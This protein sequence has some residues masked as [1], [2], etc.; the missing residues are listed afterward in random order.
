MQAC[1]QRR[2]RR[3]DAMLSPALMDITAATMVGIPAA[4]PTMANIIIAATSQIPDTADPFPMVIAP[5]SGECSDEPSVARTDLRGRCD[6]L[7]C[8]NPTSALGCALVDDRARPRPPALTSRPSSPIPAGVLPDHFSRVFLQLPSRHPCTRPRGQ[9]NIRFSLASR[10]RR[11]AFQ[12]LGRSTHTIK[13]G[14]IR[15][16]RPQAMQRTGCDTSLC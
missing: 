15:S 2:R 8:W 11:S 10:H 3:R 1:V 4:S 12:G 9:T 5:A 16:P 7:T 14:K 6:E 13:V